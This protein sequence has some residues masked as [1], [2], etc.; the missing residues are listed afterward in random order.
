MSSIIVFDES[1]SEVSDTKKKV[2][3]SIDESSPMVANAYR[4][5]LAG[6]EDTFVEAKTQRDEAAAELSSTHGLNGKRVDR[7]GV[8]AEAEL[9]V[10]QT[11]WYVSVDEKAALLLRRMSSAEA[12]IA[13]C[14]ETASEARCVFDV[15]F[16]IEECICLSVCRSA[17]VCCG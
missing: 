4:L 11:P 3:A 1:M 17:S 10:L 14:H 8:E 5:R 2:A 6:L 7:L 9:R 13:K 16:T 15:C 12:H